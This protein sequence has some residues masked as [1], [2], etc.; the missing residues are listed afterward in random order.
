MAPVVY[1]VFG[2]LRRG[3]GWS[4]EE[5]DRVHRLDLIDEPNPG[6]YV[7]RK[8]R[9]LVTFRKNQKMAVIDRRTASERLRDLEQGKRPAFVPG[10]YTGSVR[11]RPTMGAPGLGKRR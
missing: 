6:R 8:R 9:W 10:G 5:A 4:I 2:T 1:E 7:N 11:A 3:V